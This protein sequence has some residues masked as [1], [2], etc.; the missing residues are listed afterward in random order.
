M[1]RRLPLTLA[2]IITLSG[3]A[4]LAV[5]S[6]LLP[7]PRTTEEGWTSVTVL[8]GNVDE[9]PDLEYLVVLRRT[10]RAATEEEGLRLRF[11]D[12]DSASRTWRPTEI[13]NESQ[14]SESH[15]FPPET[16]VTLEDVTRDGRMEIVIRPRKGVAPHAEAQGLVILTKQ[17][18]YLRHLFAAWEG[19]PELKDL[20]G[21]QVMEIVLHAE[22]VG[23]LSPEEPILY[24]TQVFVYEDGAFRRASL[25]RYAAYLIECANAARAEYTEIKRHW[26]HTPAGGQDPK[27]LFRAIAQ[28][29]LLLREYPGLEEMRAYYLAERPWLYSRL[30]LTYLHALD[31]LVMPPRSRKK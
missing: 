24:P 28:V 5:A 15:L 21:D 18:P 31:E 12:F 6:Q 2:V 13:T 25:L 19:A 3:G 27:A 17:G 23:P 10:S 26:S 22:Y 14:G 16:A 30:P 1:R 29:L 8:S 9:D 11:F 7:P 20:D 4:R